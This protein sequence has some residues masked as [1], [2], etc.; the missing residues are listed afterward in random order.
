MTLAAENLPFEVK[1]RESTSQGQRYQHPR[2]KMGTYAAKPAKIEE[3]GKL[4]GNLRSGKDEKKGKKQIRA[5]SDSITDNNCTRGTA[6]VKVRRK[7]L[8]E[9]QLESPPGFKKFE[10]EVKWQTIDEEIALQLWEDVF[11]PLY[12]FY[13]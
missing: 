9:L 8:K 7:T 12:T 6:D 10:M 13:V 4:F 5:K 11:K 1:T 2:A 3:S